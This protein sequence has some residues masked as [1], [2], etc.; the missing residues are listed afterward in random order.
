MPALEKAAILNPTKKTQSRK[1]G[2]PERGMDRERKE[3]KREGR[4]EFI[5]WGKDQEKQKRRGRRETEGKRGSVC[6]KE[7][8]EER[9]KEKK[10]GEKERWTE[11]VREREPEMDRSRERE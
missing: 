3:G 7:I 11:L 5:V 2:P 8:R 4:R 9:N 1:A 6:K 10:E